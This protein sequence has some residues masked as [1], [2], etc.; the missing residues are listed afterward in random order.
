M[1]RNLVNEKQP[2]GHVH[3]TITQSSTMA[4]HPM[5]DKHPG[6]HMYVG[7]NGHDHSL[8]INVNPYPG[9]ESYASRNLENPFSWTGRPERG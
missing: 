7:N 1:R 4:D 9:A 8:P 2:F 3:D 6:R 5:H